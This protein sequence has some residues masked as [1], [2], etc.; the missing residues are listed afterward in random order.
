MNI[1]SIC[2]PALLALAVSLNAQTITTFSEDAFV[3]FGWAWDPN[4]SVL[5]GTEGPGDILYGE[6]TFT[7]YFGADGISVSA[8]VTTAP[9]AGF[10]F[11]LL[12]NQDRQIVANFNW[13][14]FVGGATIVSPISFVDSGFN[15][16]NVVGW[17]LVSGGSNSAISAELISAS[18]TVI[19]EPASFAA[20]AGVAILGLAVVRRR[21][22]AV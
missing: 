12:D 8:N 1:S 19:P 21:K 16:N 10:S 9:N 11:A 13:V 7:S 6:P 22:R 5:S 3:D 15:Y 18:A 14:D 2:K 4:T 17:N 20:F